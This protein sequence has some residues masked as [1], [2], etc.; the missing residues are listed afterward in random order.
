VQN[1]LSTILSAIVGNNKKRWLT[2]NYF[3]VATLAFLFFCVIFHSVMSRH[4]DGWIYM[5]VL[6]PM[7]GDYTFF[8]SLFRSFL[9]NF[10]HSDV[11]HLLLNMLCFVVVGTYLERKIG[12]IK[13]FGL[14]ILIAIFSGMWATGLISHSWVGFSLVNYGLYGFIIIDF[15]FSAINKKIR[16]KPAMIYGGV[17][18]GL[19][20]IA[21]CYVSMPYQ[22]WTIGGAFT[23]YPWDLIRHWGHYTGFVVGIGLCLIM[24]ITKI[25]ATPTKAPK[26]N[27]TI[28]SQ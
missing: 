20:Y 16:K 8:R 4:G 6:I 17:I 14:I 23:W 2:K 11:E 10:A 9:S 1:K 13:I 28:S 5:E 15:I 3:F 27:E 12:S 21:M 24:L 26:Y 19:I 22:G 25:V 18:L 7:R